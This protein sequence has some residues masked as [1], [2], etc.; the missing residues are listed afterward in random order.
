ML[1]FTKKL[2]FLHKTAISGPKSSSEQNISI[3]SKYKMKQHNLR[4]SI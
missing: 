4:M 1:R 3:V 2:D